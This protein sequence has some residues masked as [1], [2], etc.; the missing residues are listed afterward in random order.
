MSKSN[1]HRTDSLK[2]PVVEALL[3]E[4]SKLLGTSRKESFNKQTCV[5]C[6]KDAKS[7]KNALSTKEYS[8]SGMC[9]LCQNNFFISR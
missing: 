2:H 8:L 3:E 7:F 4:V 1:N 5:K 9:Q 6:G